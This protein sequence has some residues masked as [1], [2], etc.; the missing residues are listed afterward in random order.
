VLLFI[1]TR[2]KKIWNGDPREIKNSWLSAVVQIP[3]SEANVT[4][5]FQAK[6]SSSDSPTSLDLDEISLSTLDSC[7]SYLLLF[8]I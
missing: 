8:V 2:Q 3:P 7:R 5:E 4:I 6:K 1:F